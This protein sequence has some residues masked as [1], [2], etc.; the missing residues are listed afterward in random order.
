MASDA[1]AVFVTKPS[2]TLVLIKRPFSSVKKDLYYLS[3]LRD[4]KKQNYISRSS[5]TN[6]VQQVL[7][8]RT[9]ALIIKS[10]KSSHQHKMLLITT[11]I[12]FILFYNFLCDKHYSNET[13]IKK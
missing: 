9:F 1:L 10:L 8:F 13:F 6:T 4:D 7:K 12:P 11:F 2:A 3:L 5:K